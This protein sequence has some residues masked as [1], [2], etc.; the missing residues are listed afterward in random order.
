MAWSLSIL[1]GDLGRRG[2]NGGGEERKVYNFPEGF[3]IAQPFP[4]STRNQ[5]QTISNPPPKKRKAETWTLEDLE[6]YRK[7][8]ERD[9]MIISNSSSGSDP[10]SSEFP[11]RE[12]TVRHSN[13]E[14]DEKGDSARDQK[15]KSQ[16]K[17]PKSD[18]GTSDLAKPE[19]ANVYRMQVEGFDDNKSTA[20]T[21][22]EK[23]A[24]PNVRKM[25]TS[26]E[27]ESNNETPN[28][29]NNDDGLEVLKDPQRMPNTFNPLESHVDSKLAKDSLQDV[30]QEA[31]LSFRAG[32]DSAESLLE[33]DEELQRAMQHFNL[34]MWHRPWR[35]PPPVS[36]QEEEAKREVEK[37]IYRQLKLEEE[38]AV[39]NPAIHIL[40]LGAIGKYIA[41]A[42]ASLPNSPPIT[43]LMHR[44]LLIQQW[45]DEGAAIRVFTNGE[46][47]V[48]TRFNVESS[49][50]FERQYPE[51]QFPRFGPDL[52]H[53]AEPPNTLIN[54]LIVTTEP[55]ITVAA[56]SSIKHRLRKTSTICLV[57]EGMGMIE[58]INRT[59]FP[60]PNDRPTYIL[61]RSTHDLK[62]TNRLFTIVEN[63][64]GDLY[65]TKLPQVVETK[66][67]YFA[68]VVNR[69]D[70][71]WSLQARH[72]VGSL[73]QTPGLNTKS[74]GHKTFFA[75]QL[76]R[77]AVSAVIGPLSV[78]YDCSNDKL[79]YNYGASENIEHL[80]AE[81]SQIV[82]SLPEF[83]GFHLLERRFRIKTLNNI[84][85]RCI[86]KTGN[87]T[88]T[89]LQDVRAGRRTDIDFFTGY[90]VQR[91]TELGIPCPRNHMLLHLVKG[92]QATASREA[93]S[94]IPFEEGS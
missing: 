48:Q 78:A 61:G 3:D 6:L 23:I 87:N 53:S 34:G 33:D 89:M 66:E 81:I 84:V 7:H 47:H 50:K 62:S 51:Q 94:Y 24:S 45:H 27:P 15:T 19:P 68:P 13:F 28:S 9:D 42:L 10:A 92:R 67:E 41:H 26:P 65:C 72:V 11:F 73:I 82:M 57:Q 1:N 49:A 39:F 21:A 55:S 29:P 20:P 86:R 35:P 88:S 4:D 5:R 52:E 18:L 2:Y 30:R 25:R 60:D 46:Y 75:K 71:S 74:L 64:V 8:F 16:W 37:E 85:L 83:A 77:L 17:D 59:V 32:T 44:P 43:L 91:A 80:V 93:N 63:R 90:L 31:E 14:A 70:F 36:K 22:P 76:V 54:N 79:L 38:R 56:L 40:G 58:L 69:T 12:G